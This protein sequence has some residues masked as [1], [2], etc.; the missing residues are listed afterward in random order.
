[1]NVFIFLLQHEQRAICH[2]EVDDNTSE[3]NVT[4]EDSGKRVSELVFEC[5][6]SQSCCELE[7]CSDWQW[8]HTMYSIDYK[9]LYNIVQIF[10][11][12]NFR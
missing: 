3:W 7:C 6:Y 1:M 2:F 9:L 8:W 5:S 10:M 11:H 4:D 12:V